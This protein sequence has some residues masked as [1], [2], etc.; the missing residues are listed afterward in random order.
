MVKI[1]YTNKNEEII[2]DDCDYDILNKYTWYISNGNVIQGMVDKKIK[3]LNRFIYSELMNNKILKQEGVGYINQNKNDNTRNNLKKMLPSEYNRNARTL[4]K[5]KTSCY[6]GV[7]YDKHRKILVWISSIKINDKVKRASYQKEIHAVWQYNLWLIEYNLDHLL[8]LKNNIQELL[9]FIL[10]EK[11]IKSIPIL[12]IGIIPTFNKNRTIRSYYVNYKQNG[13]NRSKSFKTV[14]QAII[15]KQQEKELEEKRRKLKLK[16]KQPLLKDELGNFIIIIKNTKI[17]IDE[18]D[19]NKISMFRIEITIGYPIL[20]IEKRKVRLSR[21]LMNCNDPNL[22]VDHINNIP[23]DNRK[24]NLRIV[25]HVQNNYNKT[26]RKNSSSK[27]IGVWF[28]KSRNLWA[29]RIKKKFIG[30]FKTEIEAGKARDVATKKY[31]G[32]S[33]N[34]NFP[35]L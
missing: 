21:F 34:L 4:Y 12:P 8:N 6:K 20:N 29:V 19:Y 33:G 7:S 2:V 26:S 13:K 30:R 18:E 24:C 1:I 28:D 11:P 31:F 16:E 35:D 9:D 27:Y 32:E 3:K 25:T 10:Y 22:Q 15:F 23:L 17:L 14:P 5:N